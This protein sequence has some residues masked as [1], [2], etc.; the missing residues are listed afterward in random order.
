M[1]SAINNLENRIQKIED[2]NTK[3]ELDKKWETSSVRIIVISI[4]TYM[5]AVCVF[6]ALGNSKPFLNACIPVLGFILSTLTL[7]PLKKYWMNR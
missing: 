7:A 5:C 2:R 1:D 4:I 3:V 6:K